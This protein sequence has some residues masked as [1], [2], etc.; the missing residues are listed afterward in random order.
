MSDDESALVPLPPQPGSP[1]VG[2]PEMLSPAA[3]ERVADG[4][5]ANTRRGYAHD[6]GRFSTWCDASGLRSLPA[7]G[8]TLANYLT[9]LIETDHPAPATLDRILGTLQSHHK[10]VD[11]AV[12]AKPARLVLR[13]YRRQWSDE[14]GRVRRAAAVDVVQLRAMIDATGPGLVGLRDRTLLLLGFTMMARRSELAGL[15]LDDIRFVSE[16]LEAFIASSKTDQ[17]AH[18]A[19]VRVPYG[20]LAATCA[21]RTTHAWV[22]ALAER[23]VTEGPLL[24]GIDRHGRL[25][26]TPGATSRGTGRMSGDGINRLVKHLAAAAGLEGVTAHSLRAGSAT[27]SAMAGVPRAQI[28]RQGRW[29]PT[30]TAVDVYIRPADDWEHNPMR[31]VGL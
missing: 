10:A 9:H 18:G 19:T 22:Q 8:A 28:A 12:N 27:A 29:E 26:G 30:S 21:V 6:W 1:A 15:D 24:R 11:L 13:S 23:E 7:T 25:A 5:S 3:A 2:D 4:W 17:D 31:R 20:T 16:G 14:G